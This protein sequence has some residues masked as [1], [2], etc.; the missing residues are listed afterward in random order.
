M[1]ASQSLSTSYR[2]VSWRN[3]ICG[4]FGLHHYLSGYLYPIWHH[5]RHGSFSHIMGLLVD[6][7]CLAALGCQPL[8]QP[9]DGV[10]GWSM[11]VY[12]SHGWWPLDAQD[13][14]MFY[15]MINH[16]FRNSKPPSA[17][18]FDSTLHWVN[19]DQESPEIDKVIKNWARFPWN[20]LNL[21]HHDICWGD[22]EGFPTKSLQ[23]FKYIIE[24][25][26]VFP[27]G[28]CQ[29]IHHIVVL[30]SFALSVDP[31]F[32]NWSCWHGLE[33]SPILREK[34]R[35]TLLR[36]MGILPWLLSPS[37]ESCCWKLL[38]LKSVWTVFATDT[39]V[40]CIMECFQSTEFYFVAMLVFSPTKQK[41]HQTLHGK[42]SETWLVS[43]KVNKSSQSILPF[44]TLQYPSKPFYVLN[45]PP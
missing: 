32:C 39:S 2:M 14:A 20:H 11:N 29:K 1:Q 38:S 45:I 19:Y 41:M 17:V 21:M 34:N 27:V 33:N 37:Y 30:S 10:E 42:M 31:K 44:H 18:F 15:W 36:H 23:I 25:H 6:P 35:P 26:H 40:V 16:V 24:V 9:C 5:K 7:N 22:F 12:K 8:L 43:C 28:K 3:K 4:F 13:V